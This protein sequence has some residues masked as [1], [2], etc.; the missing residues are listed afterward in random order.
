MTVVGFD[1]GMAGFNC[2][3][4]RIDGATS[5]P[6]WASSSAMPIIKPRNKSVYR[7]WLIL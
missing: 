6:M 1:T 5:M 7:F 4:L 2:S 3:R